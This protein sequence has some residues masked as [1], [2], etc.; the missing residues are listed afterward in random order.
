MY[1]VD[2]AVPSQ[3]GMLCC[4]FPLITTLNNTKPQNGVFGLFL[5][6]QKQE[7]F[8]QNFIT[9]TMEY[10]MKVMGVKEYPCRQVKIAFLPNFLP[11]KFPKLSLSFGEGLHLLDEQIL[12]KVNQI[13]KRYN[14]YKQVAGALTFDFFG[15]RVRPAKPSYSWL[16][17]AV[18]ERI[19]DR[20]KKKKCGMLL[21]KYQVMR[22][23]EKVYQQM[24]IG[25]ETRPLMHNPRLAKLTSKLDDDDYNCP[26]E[27]SLSDLYYRKCGL[28]MHM[29]ETSI[30]E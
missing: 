2:Q 20:M 7:C 3:I 13:D 15:S 24:K 11:R 30:G 17:A 29:I 25:A 8:N 18:R 22:Q 5:N 10:L 27:Q 4:K 28:L 1:E 12:V 23:I 6:A 26:W 21:H 16:L 14:F 19:G 9:E